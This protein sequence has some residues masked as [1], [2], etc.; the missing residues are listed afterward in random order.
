MLE[1]PTSGHIEVICGPMF[2]GKSEE[3]MRRIRRAKIARQKVQTFKPEI[4]TRYDSSKIVSHNKITEDAI[5][6]ANPSII[7]D[8]ISVDTQ[9]VGVDET[10][11]FDVTIVECLN[12]LAD[13][14]IRV[15]AAGL[16][17]DYKGEP[18]EGTL[19]LIAQADFV[20]KLKAIC[21]ICGNP[22]S[23][24]ARTKHIK[25]DEFVLGS[26]DIYRAMCRKHWYEHI[27]GIT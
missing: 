18:F 8:L 2:S 6:V 3:L 11:F 7:Q 12:S 1:L 15:I 10:Q 27:E 24:T 16:D 25:T 13:Q 23:R 19:H 14:G 5:V 22:A 4:D 17:T 20:T 21:M 9:V 26:N